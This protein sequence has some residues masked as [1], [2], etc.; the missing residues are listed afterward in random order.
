[1][2][3]II[4]YKYISTVTTSV[5]GVIVLLHYNN[6]NVILKCHKSNSNKSQSQAR[7]NQNRQV[8][9]RQYKSK[10]KS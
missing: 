1:M 9:G 7:V 4:K 6:N 5:G 10:Q 3:Q 8:V 2:V